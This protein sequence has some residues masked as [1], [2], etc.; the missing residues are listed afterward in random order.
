M[1]TVTIRKLDEATKDKL[2]LR[3]ARHKRSMEDEARTILRDALADETA[4]AEDLGR[5]IHSRFKALGGLDLEL[6]PRDAIRQPPKP[7]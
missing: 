5:A 4:T 1:A 3:A 7:R 2:R 6:P